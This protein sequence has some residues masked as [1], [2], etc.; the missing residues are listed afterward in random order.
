MSFIDRIGEDLTAAMRSRDQLRLGTLRMAKAALMNR[1][2]ERGR[3]L[4]DTEAQ[5][6][7]ASLIKQRRDSVEQFQKGGRDD[8]AR[9]ELAEIAV[10][11]EYLPPPVET[12]QIE[13]AVDEAIREAGATSAKDMGRV[14][15]AVMG[16]FGTGQVDGKVVS[17]LVKR[18]LGGG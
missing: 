5:Q 10:L 6:V 8:L 12:A 7:V 2:V 13:A 9:K 15:K 14:M 18:R 1:E 16:R 17:D 4:D 3:A 11:E